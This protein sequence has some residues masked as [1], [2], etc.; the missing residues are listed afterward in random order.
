MVRAEPETYD[1]SVGQAHAKDGLALTKNLFTKS[2]RFQGV[3]AVN[4]AVIDGHGD[5]TYS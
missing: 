5:V 3:S 2:T 1:V 4:F